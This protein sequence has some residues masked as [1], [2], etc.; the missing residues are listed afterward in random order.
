M[1]GRRRAPWLWAV[2]VLAHSNIANANY[3]VGDF[4]PAARRP[5]FH[6]VRLAELSGKR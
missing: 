1:T 2:L 5:Q 3:H 6:G 4:V